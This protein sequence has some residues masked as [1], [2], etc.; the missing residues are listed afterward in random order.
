MLAGVSVEYYARMERED[1]AGV[2]A[3]ARLRR[4]GSRLDEAER[5]HL[6]DLARGRTRPM[7]RRKKACEGRHPSTSFLDAVTA[8]RWVR[9]RRMDFVARTHWAA[10][11][12]ARCS[13][14]P[15]AGRTRHGSPSS[16]R[17]APLLPRLGGE[18]GRHRGDHA[19]LC[20]AEPAGQGLTDLIG[21]L[22]TATPSGSAGPCTTCATTASG[23]RIHH[24]VVGDLEL[25]YEAM[26]LPANP[27]WFMFAYTAEP[28]SPTEERIRLLGSLAATDQDISPRSTT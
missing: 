26:D 8:L 14:T 18:R 27:D 23:G 6:D 28:G 10:P 24:P 16:I 22:V 2:S 9:D 25:S 12:R 20:R 19:H 7:R 1:L 15:P 21:E 4:T 3:G 11:W 13:R 17:R 5:D